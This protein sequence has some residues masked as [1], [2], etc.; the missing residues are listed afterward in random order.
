M[1]VIS[2]STR[3]IQGSACRSARQKLQQALAALHVSEVSTMLA[4]AE[5]SEIYRRLPIGSTLLLSLQLDQQR[6]HFSLQ[7]ELAQQDADNLE[8][9]SEHFQTRRQIG[10]QRSLTRMEWHANY[11]VVG[12]A[13][14]MRA[15][16]ALRQQ[17]AEEIMLQ[18]SQTAE[19]L[20]NTQSRLSSVQEDLRIA[21]DIQQR[22]L[23]SK[24]KLESLSPWLDCYAYM[25]PCRDIGGDFYD[26]IRL[27]ADH[28]ALVVG[29]VSGKGIP[30]AMMMATC[31][32]LLRAY[33]ESFRSASRIM[34]KI[35]PRLIEG[36]EDDC[37]FT[38]LFLGIM[39]CHRNTLTY[40][41]A[42]HNP[43]ILHRRDG[44]ILRLDD[45]HG[46][47]VGVMHNVEYEETRVPIHTGDRLLLYT[48]G[49]SETF[50]EKGELYGDERLASFC[51]RSPHELASQRLLAQLLR[52]LKR[53]RGAEQPHDD[54]TVVCLKRLVNP[55]R[56]LATIQ[57]DCDADSAGMADLMK[58]ADTFCNL[59]G[60][61]QGIS[62]RLQLVLDELLIN[63]VNYGSQNAEVLARI[64]LSLRLQSDLLVVELKDTGKPFNPFA[65]AEPDTD[66]SLE[67]REVGGL[68]VFM[69]RALTQSFSYNYEDP[70]NFVRL[71]IDCSGTAAEAGAQR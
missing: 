26:L 13:D 60:I 18:A 11:P 50:S 15:E 65:L 68:G 63:V 41:N 25:V 55:E 67:E 39:N 37:M 71:E 61:S 45:V 20:S 66:L 27:D 24:D 51:G 10:S 36:N 35:N 23:V 3:V 1:T 22:M 28:I 17:T 4:V 5:F 6:V 69:V 53:F 16:T 29:D 32:T 49:A 59:H 62:G 47:A 31:I 64:T 43:A 7:S 12:S 48:D 57:V 44:S 56:D 40:C 34:R 8:L 2:T 54:V 70:Y 42:G 58:Q 38:T 9:R 33:T 14:P 52:D 46:P 30:A 19:A 21:A